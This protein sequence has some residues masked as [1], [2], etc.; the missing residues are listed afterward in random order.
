MVETIDDAVALV[1]EVLRQA[2]LAD[3]LEQ[4]QAQAV[5]AGLEHSVTSRSTPAL[6]DWLIES[7][8]FQGVANAG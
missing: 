5:Q 2:E 4:T 1:G 7:F 6:Y 8:S 3:Y